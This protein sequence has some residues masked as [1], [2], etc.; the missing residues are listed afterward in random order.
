MSAVSGLFPGTLRAN[1]ECVPG[2]IEF[3]F[4]YKRCQ[5]KENRNQHRD[6]KSSW[7]RSAIAMA[8]TMTKG[9][10]NADDDEKAKARKANSRQCETR[11]AAPASGE[12][13]WPLSR[14]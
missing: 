2:I 8:S 13:R 10:R 3:S 12:H 1:T 4:G 9:N 6:T 5:S 7:K 11:R 14:R